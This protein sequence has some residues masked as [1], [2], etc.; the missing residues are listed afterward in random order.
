MTKQVLR[1]TFFFYKLR[2]TENEQ[3]QEDVYTQIYYYVQI[4]IFHSFITNIKLANVLKVD[5]RFYV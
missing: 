4:F 3:N 5:K 2:R 1:F